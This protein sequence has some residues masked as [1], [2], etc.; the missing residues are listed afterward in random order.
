MRFISLLSFTLIIIILWLWIKS[1]FGF[2]T[3]ILS[4][5]IFALLPPII[6]YSFLGRGYM[7]QLLFI[8]ILIIQAEQIYLKADLYRENRYLMAIFSILG[9]YTVPSFLYPFF[10]IIVILAITFINQSKHIYFKILAKDILIVI[11]VTA[12]LY[13]IL[14]P[15]SGPRFLINPDLVS[16]SFDI[17]FQRLFL[18]SQ[19]ITEYFFFFKHWVTIVVVIAT[20]S[21][22]YLLSKANYFKQVSI[23]LIITPIPIFI[24]IQ[25]VVPPVRV[26][27][28]FS[29]AWLLILLSVENNKVRNITMII[30]L[31]FILQQNFI[32]SEL[33]Y[34][35]NYYQYIA[36]KALESNPKSI[37]ITASVSDYYW[38]VRYE[39]RKK[40]IDNIQYNKKD[41]ENQA[42]IRIIEK[43]TIIKTI[44]DSDEYIIFYQDTN[45]IIYKRI[46]TLL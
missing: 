4:V 21:I 25:R 17:L 19:D 6:Q 39:E 34:H 16:L 35:K 32:K 12:C 14:I 27:F 11:G 44:L 45:T 42:D 22:I 36:Q 9:F 3:A 33:N 23:S 38:F 2:N 15:I 10:S 13:A 31:I 40:G 41:K 24:L 20:I 46:T 1:R 18:L 7:L 29:M 8:V 30:L 26:L 37:Q 28:Y 5:S 43:K